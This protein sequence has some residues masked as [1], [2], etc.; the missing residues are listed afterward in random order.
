MIVRGQQVDI[1][2]G[3]GKQ[4][5]QWL[6]SAVQERLKIF[7]TLRRELETDQFIVT[8]IR[9]TSDELINPKDRLYEHAG[10]AGLTVH[11]TVETSFPVDD[12]ENPVMNEWMEASY[13]ASQAGQHWAKE[14]AVWREN[15][16]QLK[17]STPKGA[18]VNLNTTLL[19]KKIQP[20]TS[21]L[22][23]IGFDFTEADVEV[24][25]NLDWQGLQWS[26][27]S[28]KDSQKS[29]IGDTLRKSY[30]LVCSLFNHFAGEGKGNAG[31]SA[32]S[33]LRCCAC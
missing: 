23:K 19:A 31:T 8:E 21:R 15:L 2:C 12:W 29:R 24:A 4:T 7:N 5:F 11:A 18:S 33:L 32:P 9:N 25:F 16:E 13:V 20:Q 6:A 17:S 22:V 26:W 3:D 30:S 27:A 10:Q 14:I 28:L 1:S